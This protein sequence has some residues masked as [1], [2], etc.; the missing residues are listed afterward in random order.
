MFFRSN[1]DRGGARTHGLRIKSTSRDQDYWG[2]PASN[3]DNRRP[4]TVSVVPSVPLNL[5][6]LV[7]LLVTVLPSM[8]RAQLG[9]SRSAHS[10][11]TGG[12]PDLL[13]TQPGAAPRCA[14]E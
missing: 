7:T 9:H 2:P 14:V 3:L 4:S 1:N 10:E 13:E 8:V 6:G 5:D 12:W 11:A